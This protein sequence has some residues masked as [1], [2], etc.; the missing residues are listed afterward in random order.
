MDVCVSYLFRD[1]YGYILSFYSKTTH[2]LKTNL[3]IISYQRDKIIITNWI[4]ISP[5][6]DYDYD[7]YIC[8]LL[9]ISFIYIDEEE[10]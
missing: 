2:L 7:Y 4:Y 1:Q 10:I 8:I 5:Y 6:Y 9:L 3:F